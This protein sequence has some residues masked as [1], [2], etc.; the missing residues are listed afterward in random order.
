M[1]FGNT[2]TPLKPSGKPKYAVPTRTGRMGS[3][4]YYLTPEIEAEFIRLFPV[5]PNPRMMQLFGIGFS[6]LQRLKRRYGLQKDMK[7]IKHKQAMAIRRKCEKNGYYESLRGRR[8][9]EKAIEKTRQLRATG[10]HPWKH[11]KEDA[12]AKYRALVK[13]MSASRKEIMRRE[14]R[15]IEIGIEQRTNLHLPQFIYTRSQLAHRYNAKKRGY[16]PGNKDE[17]SGQR[18]TIFYDDNTRRNEQFERNCIQDHLRI[19]PLE[20]KIEYNIYGY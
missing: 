3:T 14:R 7:V 20:I 18:Y 13:R 15:L 6:T 16:V 17:D 1:S 12:P 9:P 8:P 4:E 11:L 5:T 19:A 10:W 2:K